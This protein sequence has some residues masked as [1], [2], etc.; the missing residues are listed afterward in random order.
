MEIKNLTGQK[1]NKL[2]VIGFSHKDRHG[3]YYLCLCDCGNRKIVG[4]HNLKAGT[5]SCGCLRRDFMDITGRQFGKLTAI[6]RIPASNGKGYQ[7]L[8]KCECG[9]NVVANTGVLTTGKQKSC[10]C[11]G[12]EVSRARLKKHGM[13]RTRI[14]KIWRSMKVRTDIKM[15]HKYKDYSG[16]GITIANEWLDFEVFYK[17]AIKAGYKDNLTIDRIDVNGNYEPS[18]CRWAT[19]IE[20]GR[21]KR[22]NHR[23][24]V[25]GESLTVSEIIERTGLSKSCVEARVRRNYPIEKVLAKKRKYVKQINW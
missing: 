17:W 10:G 11:I 15:A 1:F 19:M 25:N 8:C 13:A 7:W 3:S 21:N 20:Q 9:K 12:R 5:K 24:I 2:T 6:K 16:R 23:I 22:N 18:N 14:Y 4:L